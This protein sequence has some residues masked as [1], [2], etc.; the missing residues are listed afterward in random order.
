MTPFG[1]TLVRT[2]TIPHHTECGPATTAH[3]ARLPWR[4]ARPVADRYEGRNV[5]GRLSMELRHQFREHDPAAGSGA[6]AGRTASAASRAP[7]AGST[8]PRRPSERRRGSESG[9]IPLLTPRL[10]F[11]WIGSVQIE[12]G[13]FR[14]VNYN[15][16][17]AFSLWRPN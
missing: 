9:S 17:P 7:P 10:L 11:Q 8:T 3:N 2:T 1:Q 5:L 12:Q 14:N 13:F 6:W 4:G 15:L 16:K